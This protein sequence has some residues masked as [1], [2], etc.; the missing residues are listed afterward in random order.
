M[1]TLR[2]LLVSG[3]TEMFPMAVYPVALAQLAAAVTRAGYP[4]RQYDVQVHGQGGLAGVL[5][6]YAPDL[7]GVSIRNID[8]VNSQAIRT[9][10]D[11]YRDLVTLIRGRTKARIV[12]GGSGFSLFPRE[13][14]EFLGADFGV[15]GPGGEALCGLL[16]ALEGGR[17]LS[18]VPGLIWPG[19]ASPRTAPGN[20]LAAAPLHD[21]DIVAHY[22]H[23]GGVIGIQTKRGCPRD[24]SYCTYPLIEGRSVQY[25]DPGVVV[26]EMERLHRDSGVGYFFVC[27]S[28][29]NLSPGHEIAFAREIMNR[30]LAVSWGAFFAPVGIEREYLATLKKSGLCHMEFGTDSLSEKMLASYRKGFAVE[31]VLRASDLCDE[32][33]IHAAHY[34]MFGGPGETLDS[35]R[36]TVAN[37]ARLKRSVVFPLAGVRVYPGTAVYQTGLDEGLDLKGANPFRPDFYVAPGLDL[38]GIWRLIDEGKNGAV[39]WLLPATHAFYIPFVNRLRERGYKGPLWELLL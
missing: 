9:Y 27:D 14:L 30:E 21:P 7:V 2:L 36:E 22:W 32:Q 1:G 13:I 19:G 20:G 31:D 12:L 26:D 24:C 18:A 28:L 6:S 17:E 11:E 38:S 25:Y 8:N 16:E 4:V 34:I 15:V 37:A 35:V 33:G 10:L 23:K 39:R 29:F 5:D 3:N